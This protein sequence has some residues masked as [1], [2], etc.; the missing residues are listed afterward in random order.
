MSLAKTLPTALLALGLTIALTVGASADEGGD[1]D[2]KRPAAA[3]ETGIMDR[4]LPG[5]CEH[6]IQ[7][8]FEA[9]QAK[10]FDGFL[11]WVIDTAKATPRQKKDLERFQ[12]TQLKKRVKDICDPKVGDHCVFEVTER[13]KAPKELKLF[14]KKNIQ[15]SMPCP[16][17]CAP[18]KTDKMGQGSDWLLSWA[19]CI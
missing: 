6:A 19:G 1:K 14:I 16:M 12:F 10:D 7:K 5:T 18:Q 2:K 9:A 13:R 15:P 3:P 11:K 4:T 8:V 17:K